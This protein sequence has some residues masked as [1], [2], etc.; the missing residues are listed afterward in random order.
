MTYPGGKNGAGVYQ[1]L[2]NLMPPHHTY[3]EPFLGSG[4]VMRMKRPARYSIGI[5]ADAPALE[6]FRSTS[7]SALAWGDRGGLK[8][9]H[10]D[11]VEFLKSY[12]WRG[13]E[14]VYC[15]PPYVMSSRLQARPI[16]R[17]E[18]T[19]EQ[20]E[21]LLRTLV[22]LPRTGPRAVMAMVSGYYSELYARYF[23][24]CAWRH[25][26]FQAMTRGGT[27]ATEYVWMNYPEPL[28]LHDYRYLGR[29][30][31]ERERI[32]RKKLRWRAKLEGMPA[33]ERYAILSEI[34]E[35]RELTATGGDVGRVER[36]AR[37][38]RVKAAPLAGRDDA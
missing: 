12:P 26:T 28:E 17:C 1:Q 36:H 38:G 21:T 4:A 23:D 25:V 33:L 32:K 8:L 5:D 3:V 9:I 35:L 30:F 14:L 34:E 7:S 15:D 13:G 18:M 27:P 16:Y 6:A 2:I 10:G 37:R 31:R 22:Q 11:S 29:D 24:A 19:D 20:H